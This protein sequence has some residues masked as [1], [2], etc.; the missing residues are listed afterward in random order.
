M[1]TR[2]KGRCLGAV[3]VRVLPLWDRIFNIRRR[4]DFSSAVCGRLHRFVGRGVCRDADFYFAV[5]GRLGLGLAKGGADVEMMRYIV[6]SASLHRHIVASMAS[7][8]AEH[9]LP[10]QRFNAR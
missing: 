4:D 6:T 2:I 3:Q 9:F 7:E 1:R 8:A 5:G 10:L